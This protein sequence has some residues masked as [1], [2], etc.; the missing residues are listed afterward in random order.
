MVQGKAGG[1]LAGNPSHVTAS[2]LE[3]A[4]RTELVWGWFRAEVPWNSKMTL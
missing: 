2:V 3:A 1:K 4:C